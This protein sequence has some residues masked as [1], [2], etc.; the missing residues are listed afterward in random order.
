MVV[1][2][3]KEAKSQ[4]I[5]VVEK[6]EYFKYVFSILVRILIMENI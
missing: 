2:A 5:T 4:I 6:G 3:D 1:I